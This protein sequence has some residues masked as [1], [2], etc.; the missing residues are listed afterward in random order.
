MKKGVS[1]CLRASV[2]GFERSNS[3]YS[4]NFPSVTFSLLRDELLLC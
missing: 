3:C 2:V 1:R 4:R